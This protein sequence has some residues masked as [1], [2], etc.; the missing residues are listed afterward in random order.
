MNVIYAT[1]GAAAATIIVLLLRRVLKKR[2]PPTVFAVLWLLV[3]I[4]V[5]IPVEAATHLSVFPAESALAVPANGEFEHGED[6]ADFAMPQ[7]GAQAD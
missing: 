2:V 7:F 6:A 3:L 5:L 4:R 1:L